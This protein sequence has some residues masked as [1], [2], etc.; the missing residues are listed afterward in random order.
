MMTTSKQNEF[1]GRFSLLRDCGAMNNNNWLE[2]EVK[3]RT[4]KFLQLWQHK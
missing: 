1:K 4:K 3:Y 2:G